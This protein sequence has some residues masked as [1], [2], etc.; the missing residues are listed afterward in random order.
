MLFASSIEVLALRYLEGGRKVGAPSGRRQYRAPPCNLR[1]APDPT[2]GSIQA[3]QQGTG[4]GS[5]ESLGE[6]RSRLATV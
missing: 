4:A 3:V 2:R 6:L 5:S 1:M